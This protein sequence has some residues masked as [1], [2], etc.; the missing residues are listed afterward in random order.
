MAITSQPQ[1]AAFPLTLQLESVR[2][3]K[4]SWIKISQIRTLSTERLRRRL[5]TASAEELGRAVEGLL[6]LIA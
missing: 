1:R 5:G 2:L 4:P 3:P 6:E